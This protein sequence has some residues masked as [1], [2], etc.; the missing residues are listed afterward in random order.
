MISAQGPSS[1]F[2]CSPCSRRSKPIS[3]MLLNS[4]SPR[5]QH[6]HLP[7]LRPK[8]CEKLYPLSVQHP[9]VCCSSHI[10]SRWCPPT[11]PADTPLGETPGPC[12]DACGNRR[13]RC[14]M[15]RHGSRNSP[16]PTTV[17]HPWNNGSSSC[18][19]LQVTGYTNTAP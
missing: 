11:R 8:E 18:S 6:E 17:A 13:M 1:I 9:R 3:F 5:K 12:G 15:V 7:R 10:P 16:P 14:C 19:N 4:E 2:G